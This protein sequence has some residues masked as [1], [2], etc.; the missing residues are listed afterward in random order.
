[1]WCLAAVRWSCERFPTCLLRLGERAA[2]GRREHDGSRC[3][4]VIFSG[5]ATCIPVS[6]L[7]GSLAATFLPRFTATRRARPGLA[8]GSMLDGG[9]NG[10]D[11]ASLDFSR[12]LAGVG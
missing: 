2:D 5:H 4:W 7:F 6:G 8:V 9:P 1:M 12:G 11:D 3:K 10:A